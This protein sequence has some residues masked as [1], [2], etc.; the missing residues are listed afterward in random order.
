MR[1]SWNEIRQRAA[2]FAQSWEGKGYEKGETQLFYQELFHIFDVPVRRVAVFEKQV[3]KLDDAQGYIDLFWPG[4]LL[5]E[6]KSKGR[7]LAKARQQALD[8]MHGLPDAEHPRYMLLSDFESFE[9]YDLDEDEATF[10]A[11]EDLPHHVEKLGFI[12]GV[13]KR[14]FRDQDPVNIEASEMVGAIHDAL[15]DTGYTG[16]DLERLLV[17]LVFCLFADDTG[18]FNPRDLFQELIETRT[19]E[20]GSDLGGWLM[21]LFQVLNTAEEDRLTSLDEDL[22]KF[23]YVNGDL[24]AEPLSIP[25][26]TAE[27]RQAVINACAFD[28]SAISPAIFGSLFQSVMDADERR[29]KGAHY[30]TEKNILK[31]IE[32]LFLDELHAEFARLKARKDTRRR[33]ELQA[34]QKKLASL[35]FFDPACG[36]GNF[37]VISY[38]EL[39]RLE[40]DVIRELMDYERDAEGELQRRFDAAELSLVNVDQ[41]FGIELEEFPARIAETAMWMMDHIMNNR[42]SLEFGLNAARFPLRA[43]PSILAAEDALEIDWAQLLPPEKCSYILGNPPFRGA[44]FQ[45]ADQRAQIRRIADLGGSGGT[46]DFVTGWFLK[47]VAYV[48]ATPPGKGGA[49]IAFVS[50]NSITQGEQVAQLWPLLFGKYRMEISF[51]HRTFSWGSD[52]RGKAH[53]HV[54][55]IGLDRREDVPKERR[56]FSYDDVNGNPHESRHKVLTA[57]LIDGSLLINHHLTVKEV[58]KPINGMPKLVTGSK[59]IDDGNLILNEA[60]KAELIKESPALTPYV[61]PFLGSREFLNGGRRSILYLADCPLDLIAASSDVRSRLTQVRQFREKSR[62]R[63]TQAIAALPSQF[64]VTVVPNGAYLAVPQVSSERREYIPIGWLEPPTIPSDKLRVLQEATLTEFACLTSVMHMAWM[65]TV[66]GRMKSD[67]MYSVGVVYNTFPLPPVSQEKLSKLEPLARAVLDARS[68]HPDA[69]LAQL[70]DPDLMPPGLRKAHRALDRA[71][72]A[73]YRKAPFASDRERV[74]HLF[75]LYEKMITPIEAAAAAKP[76]RKRKK[77]ASKTA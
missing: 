54:V 27:L 7:N 1:L 62:S 25:A 69:T 32:P 40:T 30:T 38:R 19:R 6:Q 50:T 72:D 37:L 18:I 70:Y 9:L 45:S 56:L 21:H 22:K 2:A 67:Y 52:A 53:V 17:R 66:T 20:D 31:L 71:V 12:A 13:Q 23:P 57:Y 74:E 10:F 39:R 41:F 55:I 16:H 3:A 51:A 47:A 59:P 34:F 28:W 29:A 43:S 61:R 76:R 33:V 75:T 35:T 42:L 8:Y 15:K 77:Q 36:C 68:E 48:R 44:K 24:F 60:E 64:H 49:R 14:T 65:R 26:F 73:M 5:V 4:V 63:P 46:L 11:L 58:S